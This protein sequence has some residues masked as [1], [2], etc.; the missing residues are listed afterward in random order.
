MYVMSIRCEGKTA[1][2]LTLSEPTLRGSMCRAGRHDH[3]VACTYAVCL[4]IDPHLRIAGLV[5]EDLVDQVAVE[6]DRVADADLLND[7][8]DVGGFIRHECPVRAGP[9]VVRIRGIGEWLQFEVSV[10]PHHH[11]PLRSIN[12]IR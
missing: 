9:P 3:D 4:V 10:Q 2:T 1:R 11:F 8:C 12:S 7:D 6:R 5:Q